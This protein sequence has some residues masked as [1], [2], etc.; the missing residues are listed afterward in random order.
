MEEKTIA[1]K[2][3]T[4]IFKQEVNKLKEQSKIDEEKS[5]N[6]INEVYGICEARKNEVVGQLKEKIT[7]L[8]N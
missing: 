5:Q 8:A 1:L 6:N 2:D 4:E 3:Q 7:E